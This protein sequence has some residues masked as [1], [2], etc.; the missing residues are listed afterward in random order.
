[1]IKGF[2]S[3]SSKDKPLVEKIAER[4]GKNHVFFDKWDLDAGD[5][6]PAKLAEGI[7][8]SESKWFILIASEHSMQSRWVRWELNI[9]IIKQIQDENYRIVVVKIDD[10]TLHPELTPYLRIEAPNDPFQ[11]VE[12]IEKVVTSDGRGRVPIARDWRR[13]ILDRYEI[14]RAVDDL[15]QIEGYKGVIL[16]GLYG[17]GKTT[18][19][20]HIAHNVFTKRLTRFQLTEGHDLLRIVLEMSA[21]ARLDLPKPDSSDEELIKAGICAFQELIRQDYVVFFDDADRLAN[22]DRHFKDFFST[23]LLEVSSNV[24]DFTPILVASQFQPRI[25]VDLQEHFCLIK[26]GPLEDQYIKSILERWLSYS[27][28]GT[29]LPDE[30]KLE[31]VAKELY[32]YPLAARLAA[33]DI[34]KYSIEQTI[35]DLSHFES[36]RIE[37][38]KQLLGRLSRKLDALQ[39]KILETLTVAGI[40]LSQRDISKVLKIDPNDVREALD[41][42]FIDQLIVSNNGLLQTI[43]LMKEYF[44][45]RINLSGTLRPI[46]YEIALHCQNQL[47]EFDSNSEEFIHYCSI[48][49]RLFLMSD[50]EPLARELMVYFKGELKEAANRL[51]RA[52]E[53]EL[54]L[55]YV[56]AWL[57]ISPNDLKAKWLR[58]R[59]LTRLERYTD[60]EVELRT[61]DSSSYSR[62]LVCHAWGLLYKQKGDNASAMRKF[63][64]GLDVKPDYLPLLRDYGDVLER[65]GDIDGAFEVLQCAYRM[66]S[67]DP[68]IAPKYAAVLET[69][70]LVEEAIEIMEI[71]IEAYPEEASLYHRLSMLYYSKGDIYNAFENADTAVRLNPSLTEAITHLAALELRRNNSERVHELLETLPDNL[72]F[73]ERRVRD[74][75]YAEMLLK[76]RQFAEARLKL[77]NYNYTEDAHC[78]DVLSRIELHEASHFYSQGQVSMAK[79]RVSKGLRIVNDALKKH[80]SDYFLLEDLRQLSK[81]SMSLEN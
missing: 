60:A 75:I 42:L 32:G 18:V 45:R 53:Y 81:L 24:D 8:D 44:W 2:L 10:C 50:N 27:N 1:M 17:I 38:A 51:F 71:L 41:D 47:P 33:Y 72:P 77:R 3:H 23:F 26:V 67:R 69:K 13:S 25:E 22:E 39:L 31:R 34:A 59:C 4:L 28:P 56:E 15:C 61:L 40:G 62:H 48:A 73:R 37:I 35:S 49:C 68:Y 57:S 12:E 74:T 43:P 16:W 78:A 21:R 70:G 64:E 29:E 65:T 20:E 76:Q 11:V 19:A 9:A 6:I 30:K 79:D 63:R 52:R 5:I 54:S 14:V 80:P 66:A 36:L 7:V 55:R 46:S 58:A